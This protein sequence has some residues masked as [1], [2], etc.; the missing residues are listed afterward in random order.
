MV[1]Y[2][3]TI[4][5]SAALA[6][7]VVAS[8]PVCSVVTEVITGEW[9]WIADPTWAD[10]TT[11]TTTTTKKPAVTTTTTFDPAW[12]DWTTTTTTTTPVDPTWLDWTTTTTTTKKPAVTTTTTYVDPTWLDWTTTTTTTTTTYVDPTW[13]DWTS[14]SAATT[15]TTPA[16]VYTTTTTTPGVVTTTTTTTVAPPP[17]ATCPADNGA[18]VPGAGSCECEYQVNCNV[19]ADTSTNPTFWQTTGTVDT[20]QACLDIC[21]NNSLCTATIWCDDSSQCGSDYHVCWQTSGLGGVAGAGYGQVSYKS[22]CKGSCSSSY[23]S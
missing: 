1:K 16:P 14:S 6:T 2:T 12:L 22:S 3:S 7:T 17:S 23:N 13:L 20:L 11:A 9:E 15:T 19:H 8:D 5:A 21:D 18:T 4:L 10:W